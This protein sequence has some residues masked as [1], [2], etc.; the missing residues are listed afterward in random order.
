MDMNDT[1][2]RMRKAGVRMIRLLYCDSSSI[3]RT[4]CIHID[5]FFEIA[6]C[7][8]GISLFM[9]ALNICDEP[10]PAIHISEVGE[11]Y[12]LP[13][14][15]TLVILKY[16]PWWAS[17]MVDVV[18]AS[19][20][21]GPLC[22][23][24]FLSRVIDSCRKHGLDIRAAFENE[25][26]L[27]KQVAEEFIPIDKS[28]CKSSSGVQAA[29]S[30]IQNLVEALNGV[31]IDIEQ[32]YVETG[33]GQQEITMASAWG[34]QAADNQV[35]FRETIREVSSH[36]GLV[37]SF[38][39][40]PFQDAE[41]NGCHL[42]FSLWDAQRQ[43]NLFYDADKPY[44]LSKVGEQFVAGILAHLPGIM[45]LTC[46][47]L[48]SYRRLQP[49][50]GT[51]AFIC[52]G[53]NNREAAIRFIPPSHA[54]PV[55]WVNCELKACDPS[56][57]PYLALGGLLVCGLDGIKQELALPPLLLE[58]PC[59]LT[60]AERISRHIGPY[61]S[62]LAEAI[63]ALER[64][65]TLCDALGSEMIAIYTALK[66]SELATFSDC[67]VDTEFRSHFAIF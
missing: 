57:N 47:T 29:A 23:R 50:V 46:P 41:A 65:R 14:L 36:Q 67:D 5:H 63:T 32:Y 55:A 27:V 1:M 43:T 28:P 58:D 61:P 20:V 24:S 40:K 39:P 62:N 3:I 64:D 11:S 16:A 21:P 42:H 56:C 34:I 44:G 7:G 6:T 2:Y 19:H 26:T 35:L 38:A 48:N 45:A 10:P 18:D 53:P 17:V 54:I 66:R 15:S 52:W 13:D 30:Y 8:T 37:A 59:K 4:K 31:G 33:P 12:M 49:G 60:D 22:P 25:F 51:S 9:Q